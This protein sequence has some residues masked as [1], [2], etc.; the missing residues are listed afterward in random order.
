MSPAVSSL[1]LWSSG[2]WEASNQTAAAEG[3]G[4]G[5]LG[6]LFQIELRP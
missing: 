6:V 1:K 3:Q 5:L 2:L 4:G